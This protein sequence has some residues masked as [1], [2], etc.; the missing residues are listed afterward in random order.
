V[1][2]HSQQSKT[3]AP[4][5]VI[6]IPPVRESDPTAAPTRQSPKQR[7]P[8]DEASEQVIREPS[9]PDTRV[10]RTRTIWSL[11]AFSLLPGVVAKAAPALW[12]G[13]PAAWHW[14][15]YVCSGV[16]L[17]AATVLMVK[18]VDARRP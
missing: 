13:L 2:I 15:A 14:A 8:A 10:Y 3:P 11:L 17:G 5:V 4:R 16:L 18:P 6:E 1:A 9:P 7:G 12:T